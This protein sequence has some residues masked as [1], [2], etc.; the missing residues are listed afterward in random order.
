MTDQVERVAKA[1]YEVEA[2]DDMYPES[3]LAWE[4]FP[5]LHGPFLRKA[6]AAIAALHPTPQEGWQPIETAPKDGTEVLLYTPSGVCIGEWEPLEQDSPDQPGHN[7]GWYGTGHTSDPVMW[8]RSAEFG[9]VGPGYL[10]EE[11][12]QP[13]HWMPLPNAPAIAGEGQ[14]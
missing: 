9:F 6:R 14:P 13:T 7:P 1:I 8:G 5:S 11:Q 2:A 10:Y 12:N 3:A 4:D